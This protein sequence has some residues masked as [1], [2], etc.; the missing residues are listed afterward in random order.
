MKAPSDPAS[1]AKD[2]GRTH[3]AC[4]PCECAAPRVLHLPAVEGPLPRSSLRTVSRRSSGAPAPRSL[5]VLGELLQAVW[6]QAERDLPAQ[7]TSAS[8]SECEPADQ[9]LRAVDRVPT[10]VAHILF[11][12]NQSHNALPRFSVISSTSDFCHVSLAYVKQ[13]GHAPGSPSVSVEAFGLASNRPGHATRERP[14]ARGLWRRSRFRGGQVLQSPSDMKNS[15]SSLLWESLRQNCS[16]PTSLLCVG[17]CRGCRTRRLI[18][19]PGRPR[20][21]SRWHRELSS[22]N[23]ASVLGRLLSSRDRRV[24]LLLSHRPDFVRHSYDGARRGNVTVE[25]QD[26]LAEQFEANRTACGR[27]STGCSAR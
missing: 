25:E 9:H 3:H 2:P 8:L 10:V 20:P 18:V 4:S 7:P 11:A 14:S 6:V 21:G 13:A 16:S 22:L 15:F 1:R 23:C 19:V 12:P 27:W 24:D 5:C 17:L 26:W